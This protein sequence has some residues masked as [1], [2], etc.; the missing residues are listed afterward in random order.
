MTLSIVSVPVS[1]SVIKFQANHSGA[2][3]AITTSRSG[4][5][6]EAA[7]LAHD[8]QLLQFDRHPHEI[9]RART[10]RILATRVLLSNEPAE[11]AFLD[12]DDKEISELRQAQ[13][14]DDFHS[15]H[16]KK[17]PYW[18]HLFKQAGRAFFSTTSEPSSRSADSHVLCNTVHT[19][20]DQRAAC[21]SSIEI[22]GRK[23]TRRGRKTL[24]ETG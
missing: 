13:L 21:K 8:A 22:R 19:R 17:S 2:N 7:Q 10:P 4:S 6:K 20:R 5:S 14:D 3:L 24:A 11:E 12:D 23:K 16:E 15:V 1:L 18:L 9:D